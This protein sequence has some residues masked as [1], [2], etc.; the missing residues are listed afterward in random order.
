MILLWKSNHLKKKLYS[1]EL[2]F[3][4]TKDF[5]RKH[6]FCTPLNSKGDFVPKNRF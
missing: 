1:E 6:I 4:T 5:M 2:H 3:S